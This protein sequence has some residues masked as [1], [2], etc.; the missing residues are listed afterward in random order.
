MGFWDRIYAVSPLKIAFA[1]F[2]HDERRLTYFDRCA[3]ETGVLI[4]FLRGNYRTGSLPQHHP[5]PRSAPQNTKLLLH[6]P[7]FSR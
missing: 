4:V 1:S 3:R 5:G 7:H 2:R 6:G